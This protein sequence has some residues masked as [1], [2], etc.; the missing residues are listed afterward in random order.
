MIARPYVQM[1]QAFG[2]ENR[3][4]PSKLAKNV[5]RKVEYEDSTAVRKE[6]S[7]ILVA[8]LP[9]NSDFV[10]FNEILKIKYAT[11]AKK[12]NKNK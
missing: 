8:L 1:A 11:I 9:K 7:I 4:T 2:S 6:I 10:I 12:P 5:H 3:C